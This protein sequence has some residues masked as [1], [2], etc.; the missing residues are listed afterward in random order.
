MVIE[1]V[2]NNYY[3][4]D[5]NIPESKIIDAISVIIRFF[6]SNNNQDKQ[7]HYFEKLKTVLANIQVCILYFLLIS[8]FCSELYSFYYLN[9][10]FKKDLS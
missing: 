4:Q 1:N 8:Y 9:L 3:E 7:L 5:E 6:K 2:V 10:L